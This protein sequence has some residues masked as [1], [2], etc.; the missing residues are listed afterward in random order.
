MSRKPFLNEMV[1]GLYDGVYYRARVTEISDK[2]CRLLYVDYGDSSCNKIGE[3]YE[4][5]DSIMKVNLTYL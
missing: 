5:N 4:I 3:M 2:G 1:L